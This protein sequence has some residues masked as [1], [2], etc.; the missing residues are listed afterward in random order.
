MRGLIIFSSVNS[1]M[2]PMRDLQGNP[3][4]NGK[5]AMVVNFPYRTFKK[6]KKAFLDA[7]ILW[8]RIDIYHKQTFT[9]LRAQEDWDKLRGLMAQFKKKKARVVYSKTQNHTGC[10]VCRD[11]KEILL[12]LI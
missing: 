4:K 9:I 8:C 1:E 12:R 2:Q 3:I 5:T 11:E 10:S 6:A 7:K